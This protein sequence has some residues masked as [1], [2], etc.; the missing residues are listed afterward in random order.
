MLFLNGDDI[1]ACLV[2]SELMD[3]MEEAMCL[4]EENRVNMPPR[5][6][7]TH[8]EK[9]LLFMPCF[10]VDYFCTKLVSVFPGNQG[11]QYPVVN[12]IVIL[13]DVKTA[14]PV[15][16]LD[17]QTLTGIRTGAVGGLGMRHFSSSDASVVGLVGA[18]AQGFHQILFSAA[19]HSQL[20]GEPLKRAYIYDRDAEKSA[21]LIKKLKPELQ[22]TEFR[23]AVTVEELLEASQTIITATASPMP[24]LPD[25]P[26]LFEGK[27]LVG[28][29]SYTPDMQEFP[30]S[31]FEV[32]DLMFLD[33]NHAAHES[34]D[35][36]NPLKNRWISS[37]K[38]QS[39]GQFLLNKKRRESFN[40][41]E[42]VQNP[43]SLKE[44]ELIRGKTVIYKSVG[45]AVFDLMAAVYIFNR[46]RKNG[47][48]Q[49]L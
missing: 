30:K 48:G 25:N 16:I 27:C 44:S 32:A 41:Q 45:M 47:L 35:V 23:Q 5:T 24:V 17:G 29:G 34:G 7:V 46:A 9:A 38:V 4:F 49:D 33:T 10:G 2:R 20:T 39:L 43:E 15:A 31:A 36:I 40:T 19:A 26:R 37:D 3:Q 13:N 12:G 8:G 18:G 11:T 22:T 21:D 14:A 42:S 28:I 1:K 6:N